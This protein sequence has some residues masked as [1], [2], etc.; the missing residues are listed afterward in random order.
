M[1]DKAV[2]LSVRE[3]G[4]LVRTQQVSPVELAETF[5]DRLQTL[6]PDY[7]AVVTVTRDR[8]LEEARTAEREIASGEYKGVL[9]GVPYG[10]KDLLA[11]SGGIA[12]SW[13]A[14]PL[15]DQT[16]D[17]DATVVTR[18][19]NTGAVLV[20]K[21]AMV[22]LAG[23][24]GYRQPNASFTGP[25]K[26]PWDR[27]R[28]AGG[29]SSG[30]GAAVAAG[31][32][33]FAIGSE[34][35]GSILSPA[36]N[37][38]V[39]GLRP[40][41]GRVSRYGAMALAWSLDKLGPICLTADDC[42][43][44]LD[45]IAG[46][47]ANDPSTSDRP[48]VYEPHSGE[49]RFR[50]GVLADAAEGVEDAVRDNLMKALGVLETIA[51]VEE[52]RLPDLPYNAVAATISVAEASSSLENLVDNDKASELTAPEDR[53]GPY[54]RTAVLARDYL[55]ALRLRGVI[56]READ[57]VL[58]RVDALVGPTMGT[59]A[60]RLDTTFRGGGERT[61]SD[62]LGAVGNVAGLPSI[63]VP[64]GFSNEGLPTGIQF[65]GRAYDENT[66]LALA[67]AYQSLT[68]WHQ[69]HPVNLVPDN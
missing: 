17:Y 46:P 1:A 55:K 14:A 63:S 60:S 39:A 12:T 50:L 41:Y 30:S 22:E 7:N 9:H 44:V 20:A 42:G 68:D 10:V 33:P 28:W 64:S 32:V 51:D 26:T 40:T 35:R 52:V 31:L 8:A 66:V 11:T 29:S 15:R 3:V 21:L 38:G 49:R 43:L 62:V 16:F 25:C 24:M 23:G 54:G 34:T 2:F 69:R 18:L 13:G 57:D 37:C 59:V 4:E 47:D 61:Y 27:D 67:T 58:S 45:A 5:L 36:N 53:Y 19:S 6:G 48:Y 65:V 56:G